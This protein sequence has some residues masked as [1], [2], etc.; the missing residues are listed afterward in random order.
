MSKDMCWLEESHAKCDIMWIPSFDMTHMHTA[1]L[2]SGHT[3]D[4]LLT[5]RLQGG[6][7][8]CRLEHLMTY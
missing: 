4:R 2:P 7:S 1:G 6:V 5:S 8:L 3:V